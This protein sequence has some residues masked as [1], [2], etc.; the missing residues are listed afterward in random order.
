MKYA[1]FQFC[2][3]PLHQHYILDQ[4]WLMIPSL[5]LYRL[6]FWI[7][8]HESEAALATV[9]TIKVSR[10]E[11][12]SS[13]LLSWTLSSQTVD[14]TIVIHLVI[15]QLCQLNLGVL[16]LD[17]LRGGVVL[18]LPLL[19]ATSQSEDQVQGGLLLDV[20][21]A[22]SATILQLLASEDQ[23]LL[24]RR[25]SLLILDL[26]FDILNGVAGFHLQGDG[27]AREGLHE[28]LHSLLLSQ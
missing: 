4:S 9:L 6:L 19:G 11:H 3:D 17:L 12:P 2:F 5:V 10:H 18:L 7:V 24:I 28:N 14:L 20:V 16:V 13:T 22:E 21:V 1:N 15:L 26:S 8:E 23:P 25:N 27:L